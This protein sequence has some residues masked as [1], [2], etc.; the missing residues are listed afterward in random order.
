MEKISYLDIAELTIFYTCM[1]ILIIG[2]IIY[3]YFFA[4]SLKNFNLGALFILISCFCF[5]LF[6]AVSFSFVFHNNIPQAL[7]LYYYAQLSTVALMP[8]SL[9]YVMLVTRFENKKIN[10]FNNIV[11]RFLL[12]LTV[13]IVFIALVYPDLFIS[14]TIQTEFNFVYTS[15]FVIAQGNPGILYKV[16]TIPFIL[17]LCY[18]IA[19]LFYYVKANRLWRTHG[20][21]VLGFI[22]IAFAGAED[23]LKNSTGSALFFNNVAIQRFPIGT[24]VFCLSIMSNSISSFVNDIIAAYIMKEKLILVKDPN[25]VII[26]NIKSTI[27]DFSESENM[28]TDVSV[29][30]KEGANKLTS[31]CNIVSLYSESLVDASREF[32][33]IDKEQ[34][35][36]FVS[37]KKMIN[38][39][40]SSFTI[41]KFA[42]SKQHSTIDVSL[43][44]V[45]RGMDNLRNTQNTIKKLAGVSSDLVS[46]SVDIREKLVSSF[47][48]LESIGQISN[49]IRKSI[50]FIKDI[51]DKTNLLAINASI[52][53]SKSG[54]YGPSFSLVAK[55]IADLAIESRRGADKIDHLFSAISNT[56]NDFITIKN[57]VTKGFDSII[58]HIDTTAVKIDSIATTVSKQI[59]GSGH[60][61]D[62]IHETRNANEYISEKI[63][64]QNNQIDVINNKLDTLEEQFNDLHEKSVDQIMEIDKLSTEI[65]STI[66][67]SKKISEISLGIISE[68][69]SMK[70]EFSGATF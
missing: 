37:N 51:S 11:L 62:I 3:C 10:E 45:R 14:K 1:G 56:L 49:Q 27:N 60:I 41:L 47:Q 52:Q 28:L 69:E 33:Y 63:R 13:F 64:A 19:L 32:E 36:T 40:F 42:I 65:Y 9:Y 12:F 68:S 21:I 4:K 26:K 22:V 24:V 23:M 8:F 31:F 50:S 61:L 18:E 16:R 34:M 25:E 2:I 66:D 44:N 58:N 5:N 39:L 38:E 7:S 57:Y 48:K 67:L 54:V 59:E 46:S 15:N 20:A 70:E 17:L 53:S 43:D 30:L 55:E 6:N 35:E 29:S